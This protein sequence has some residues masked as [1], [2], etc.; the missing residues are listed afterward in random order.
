MENFEAYYDCP[1]ENYAEGVYYELGISDHFFKRKTKEEKAA[2][3]EARK[4]KREARKEKRQD[5][6]DNL[7]EKLAGA[8]SKLGQIGLLLPFKGAMKSA[9]DSKSIKH[10]GTLDD[11]SEKFFNQIVQGGKGSYQQVKNTAHLDPIIIPTIISAIVA[12]FRN[13]KAKK[14]A[15]EEMPQWQLEALDKAETATDAVINEVKYSG[16]QK[17]GAIILP[18]LI[19]IIVLKFVRK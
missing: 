8:V 13:L 2:R 18:I 12:F 17:L 1:I 7:K 5:A 10:D 16:Q 11:I 4:E 3:K 6:W 9:L 15:G 14:E 19:I